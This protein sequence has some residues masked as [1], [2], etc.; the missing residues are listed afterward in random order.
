MA[1]VPD[2]LAPI[3]DDARA[4]VPSM[5]L[6]NSP[7][8]MILLSPPDGLTATRQGRERREFCLICTAI[9]YAGGDNR[10]S[11]TSRRELSGH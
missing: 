9:A 4:Q 2:V 6:D 3:S 11:R 10:P 5:R 1:N 8:T 7:Q